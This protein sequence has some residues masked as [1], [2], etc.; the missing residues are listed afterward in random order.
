MNGRPGIRL[1]WSALLGYDVF[2]S[3]RR[4][5]ATGYAERLCRD[6]KD[7]GLTVFLDQDETPGGTHLAPALE[8]ALRRSRMLVLVLTPHV[9]ESQWI[10]AEVSI[11]L[12]LRG[13]AVLPVNIDGYI[14][15]TNLQGTFL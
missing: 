15:K 14:E 2:I 1:A 3:Y 5:E 13:R 7:R 9:L 11:C 4:S 10:E 12:G 8:R 6:L